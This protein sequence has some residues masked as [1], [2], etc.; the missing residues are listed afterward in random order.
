MTGPE[1][2]QM[3]IDQ[4]DILR[5]DAVKAARVM[6]ICIHPFVVGQPHVLKLREV[7]TP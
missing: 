3:I 6:A 1:F 2:G 7:R 5:R 4:F